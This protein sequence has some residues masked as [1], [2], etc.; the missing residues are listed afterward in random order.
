MNSSP[1]VLITTPDYFPKLG[2]LTTFTSN[3]EKTLNQIG[4]KYDLLV[5]KSVGDLRY[6]ARKVNEYEF[7]INIHFMAGYFLGH[8]SKA[9]QINICHGSEILFY[10]PNVI[11]KMIKK[12]L[13]KKMLKYLEESSLNLIISQFTFEKLKN[14]GLVPDYS[15]DLIVHNGV[16]IEDGT[17]PEINDINDSKLICVCVARDVPH[18]NIAGAVEFCEKLSGVAQKEVILFTTASIKEK[19]SSKIKVLQLK[20]LDEKE[21]ENAFRKAHFNLLLSLDHSHKGFYEGFG[22]TVLEAGKYGTPSVV[23]PTGGLTES[24]HHSYTGWVVPNN[25]YQSIKDFWSGVTSNDYSQVALN[26]YQHTKISHGLDPYIKL[27]LKILM[28]K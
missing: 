24:V 2:G 26:C 6:K 8:L 25:N 12:I 14:Q 18:K 21:K 17:T 16:V 3:V 15:R 22:L 10:S 19:Y 7:I 13:R 23:F 5:W 11:K 28:E 20:D 9:K 1:N 27:F 4:C